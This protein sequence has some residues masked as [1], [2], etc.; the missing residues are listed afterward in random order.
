MA[1]HEIKI[2]SS[3]SCDSERDESDLSSD[4]EESEELQELIDEEL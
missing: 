2:E 1:A 4:G 3:L